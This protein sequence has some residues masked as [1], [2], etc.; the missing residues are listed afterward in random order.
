[1]STEE[2]DLMRDPWK[3]LGH[4]RKLAKGDPTKRFDHLY[5]LVCHPKLLADA[6]LQVQENTGSRTP[7]IDGQTG[8]QINAEMLTRLAQELRT[9][10]YHPQAVRRVYIPKGKTGRRGLGIPAIGDRIVQAAVALILARIYEPILRDCSYGF[11][12]KRN[13][14]Q[15]LRHIA[16]AYRAGATWV[17][18]GDLVKCFDSLPHGVILNCL[19]KRIRDERFIDLQDAQSGCD[20]GG[21]PTASPL[22]STTR[23]AGFAHSQQYRASRVRLLD[24]TRMESEPAPIDCQRAECTSQP[25]MDAPQ[26]Q[27]RPLESSTCRPSS[28]GTSN[29]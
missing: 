4:L 22:W 14:M 8:K 27:P 16:Q 5:P 6:A 21:K 2:L 9:R 24:G 25:G 10:H 11:R 20:G 29:A 28:S 26:A 7:G 1:M 19:R 3:E 23:R 12:P 13:T 18:E 15:A 17:I